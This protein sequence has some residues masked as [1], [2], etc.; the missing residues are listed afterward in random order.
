MKAWYVLLPPIVVAGAAAFLLQ[1]RSN[2]RAIA[3][4]HEQ[5]ES[6]AQQQTP[7]AQP[8][9]SM[10]AATSGPST[11]GPQPAAERVHERDVDPTPTPTVPRRLTKED[12]RDHY[13]IAFM[14][15][16]EDSRWASSARNV[17]TQRI[18]AALPA[19]S[20]LRAV[21]CRTSFC[22]I[23]TSHADLRHFSQ[24]VDSALVEPATSVWNGATF[25]TVID[26]NAGGVVVV[27]YVSREGQK[28]PAFD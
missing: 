20:A 16:P 21:D 6:L 22:R 23:E 13:E 15:E 4:I 25:S 5:L 14:N 19:G 7:P 18:Q 12:M 10:P 1:K 8:S 9:W 3:Q 26:S 2:D 27:S 24:F 17:A 28:L 11:G